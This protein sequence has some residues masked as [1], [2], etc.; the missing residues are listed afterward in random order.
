VI[1][2]CGAIPVF[3]DVDKN[4]GNIL[5]GE[6]QKH[7]TPRTRAIIPV[8]FAGRPCEMDEI[9]ALAERY[10]LLLIEDA[11]HALEAVYRGRKVGSIGDFATFSFYPTK[12]ITTGDGGILST[13]HNEWADQARILRLHGI[14]ADAW[15]RYSKSGYS[16]YDVIY[17]GYKYNMTDLQAALGLHQI[18][19]LEKNL[20]HREILWQMYD[21]GLK[22]LSS[23]T[24]LSDFCESDSV[25]ARH[26]YTIMVDPIVAGITR[27]ELMMRLKEVNIG[28]GV[29]FTAL[30]EHKFFRET[31]GYKPGDYPNAKWISDRTLSLPLTA[32]MTNGD[33]EDVV[34]AIHWV[35]DR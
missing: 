29:H 34:A 1:V 25:H 28:T 2:H 20:H 8:H 13:N 6:I 22:D 7:I 27:D 5:P 11:A 32:G 18:G 12:S 31:F 17:P 3:A 30:H 9:L 23:L 24:F 33:V 35:L 15:K 21:D 10:H 14:S 26:L 19:R 16:H 4:T